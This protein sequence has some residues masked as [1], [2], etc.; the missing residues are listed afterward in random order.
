MVRNTNSVKKLKSSKPKEQFKT[1]SKLDRMLD[2]E[3]DFNKLEYDCNVKDCKHC[4]QSTSGDVSDT[5]VDDGNDTSEDDK[6]AQDEISEAKAVNEASGV[7]DD[8]RENELD[9]NNAYDPAKVFSYD[10]TIFNE[11]NLSTTELELHVKH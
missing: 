6:G 9:E 11:N 7:N 2:F 8:N 3:F 1:R 10:S 4:G 5:N